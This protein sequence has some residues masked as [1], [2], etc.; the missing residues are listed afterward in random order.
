MTNYIRKVAIVGGGV[1]GGGW[2]ALLVQ[3]GID[4]AVYDPDPQAER[5]IGEVIANA[6]RAFG[7]LTN[8][9]P[10]RRGAL[11]F[12][13]S[14]EAAVRDADL[15]QESAPERLALKRQLL[16]EIEQYAAADALI[17]SSTSGLLPS[18][19]QEGLSHPERL[20]VAHPFNPVY[21]LPLVEI[22]GGRQTSAETYTGLPPS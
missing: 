13:A 16:A 14:I 18:D 11:S 17:G 7:K 1:I 2:A 21:L 15:I 22:V 19:L 10:G 20:V 9:P 6:D 12:A 4:V 5:K 3:N 8:A